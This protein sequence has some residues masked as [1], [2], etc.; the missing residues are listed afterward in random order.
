MKRILPGGAVLGERDRKGN[1]WEVAGRP[2]AAVVESMSPPRK[3]SLI[4]R[5]LAALRWLFSKE[6]LPTTKL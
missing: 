6:Q 3:P 4:E 2:H 1:E 5:L